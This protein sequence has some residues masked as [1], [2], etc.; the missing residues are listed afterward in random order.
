VKTVMK[1]WPHG[2][3]EK[4]WQRLMSSARIDADRSS[5]ALRPTDARPACL[6]VQLIRQ[7]I[8]RS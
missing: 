8:A 2:V 7:R 5:S 6:R 1:G 4:S 3:C